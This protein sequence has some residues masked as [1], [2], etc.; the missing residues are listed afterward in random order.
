MNKMPNETI[1][2]Y[3]LPHLKKLLEGRI[4]TG[5]CGIPDKEVITEV[6]YEHDGGFYVDIHDLSSDYTDRRSIHCIA[7]STLLPLSA[8]TL[9]SRT[10]L[11]GASQDFSEAMMER[12]EIARGM[13]IPNSKKHKILSMQTPAKFNPAQ[14]PDISHCALGE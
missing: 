11:A 1:K 2:D 7:H 6:G 9:S 8:Q 13:P 14:S 4:I 5:N 12:G 3:L 10:G